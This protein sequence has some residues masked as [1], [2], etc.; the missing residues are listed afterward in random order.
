MASVTYHFAGKMALVTGAGRGIGRATAK[1]LVAAG[2]VTYGLSKTKENLDS[3][4]SECPDIRTVC[5]DL[6]DWDATK[7]AVED[8]GPIDLLVNNAGV[9]QLHSFLE[10]EPQKFDEIY[11]VNVKALMCVSQVVAKGMIAR[12]CSG[13]IVNVSSVGSSRAVKS[14]SAYGSSKAAVDQLTRI[15]ALELGPHKIR[16]NSVNPTVVMTDLGK[17]TWADPARSVPFLARHP[18]GKFAEED[19][20]ANAIMFLLSDKAGMIDGHSLPIDGGVWAV[21]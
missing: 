12:G 21:C 15:M 1:A 3:L 9:L 6:S 17:I 11:N 18:L 4:K 19:D 13:S 7:K 2:A 20:V 10:V 5:V 14:Y 8:I 16:V